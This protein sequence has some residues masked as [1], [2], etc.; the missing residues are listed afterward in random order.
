MKQGDWRP[1]YDSNW[2]LTSA[3]VVCRELHCGSV[4]STGLRNES[5]LQSS[6][7]IRPDCVQSG[8]ALRECVSPMWS[9]FFLE[10]TCSGKPQSHNTLYLSSNKMMFGSCQS[11][12]GIENKMKTRGTDMKTHR[13]DQ[14]NLF[15]Q[16]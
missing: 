10:V 6:W 3:A 4:V 2:T 14:W 8:S 13:E 9:S 11:P 15:S 12:A 5:T 1:V 16:N 7:A